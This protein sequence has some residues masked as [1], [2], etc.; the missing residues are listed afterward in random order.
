MDTI[1]Y[2][3]GAIIIIAFI[4]FL[5]AVFNCD[6]S[7][8]FPLKGF[9]LPVSGGDKSEKMTIIRAKSNITNN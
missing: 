7:G 1:N 5:Y 3:A 8:G 4:W 6:W 2:L 9:C